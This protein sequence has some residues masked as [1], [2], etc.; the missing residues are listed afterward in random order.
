MPD[1]FAG[2]WYSAKVLPYWFWESP[3]AS[4]TLLTGVVVDAS[5]LPGASSTIGRTGVFLPTTTLSNWLTGGSGLIL[6]EGLVAGE[7]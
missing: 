5:A 4:R 3:A 6:S 2:Y 1:R 7:P